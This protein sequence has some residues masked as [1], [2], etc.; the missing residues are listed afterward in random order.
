MHLTANLHFSRRFRRKCTTLTVAS[1]FVSSTRRG[2][3]FLF[4]L[5]EASEKTVFE[6]RGKPFRDFSAVCDK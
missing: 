3:L 2:R 1:F 4:G 5:S 6:F